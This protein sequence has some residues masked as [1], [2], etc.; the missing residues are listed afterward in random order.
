MSYPGPQTQPSLYASLSGPNDV[1]RNYPGPEVDAAVN[2]VTQFMGFIGFPQG[3]NTIDMVGHL[4][5]Y[6]PNLDPKDSY[7]ALFVGQLTQQQQQQNPWAKYGMDRGAYEQAAQQMKAQYYSLSGENM[8]SDILD[9]ALMDK[10]D[11]TSI[12]NYLRFDNPAGPQPQNKGNLPTQYDLQN[13]P[14]VSQGKTYDQM[15]QDYQNAT[16]QQPQNPSDL[17]NWWNYT[18]GQ[19]ANPLSSTQPWLSE[20]LTYSQVKQQFTQST[21]QDPTSEQEIQQWY[22]ASHGIQNPLLQS[23]PWL[24][25]GLSWDQV[26]QQYQSQMGSAPSNQSDVAEWYRTSKGLDP[27]GSL[28]QADP[29]VAYGL[30]KNQATQQF[31]ESLGRAPTSDQEIS[32]WFLASKGLNTTSQLSQQN[33]WLEYGM[34]YEQAKQQYIGLVGEDPSDPSQ[35]RSLFQYQHGS[36][37]DQSASS[38]LAADPWVNQGVSYESARSQYMASAGGLP[39]SKAALASWWNFNQSAKGTGGS[40]GSSQ[41]LYQKQSTL[42][43]VEVK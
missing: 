39:T 28:N 43:D 40:S 8:P 26:R 34:S 20:G 36:K 16:G 41:G 11:T 7:E 14:W 15:V 9:R 13:H 30:S 31:Q 1:F 37:P 35:V 33:P 29:W 5:K 21:G 32:D 38:I 12:N 2:L 22:N 17:L 23:S 3:V 18:Q 6:V 24:A 10:W 4:L 42:S 25:D 27:T 19:A